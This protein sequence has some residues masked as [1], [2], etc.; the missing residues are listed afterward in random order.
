MWGGGRRR[1]P[2]AG[3]YSPE[4]VQRPT[5]ERLLSPQ[6]REKRCKNTST[7]KELALLLP[8]P[9]QTGSKK[10]TKKEI[11]Q[12]VL[13]YIK[14][15]QRSI[16]AAK[17]VLRFQHVDHEVRFL[18]FS[19]CYC[20]VPGSVET[21]QLTGL[22]TSNWKRGREQSP[23]CTPPHTKRPK[24]LGTCK[25]PRKSR[26]P[27][28]TERKGAPKKSSRSLLLEKA[29]QSEKQI[30]EDLHAEDSRGEG[31]MPVDPSPKNEPVPAN[32]ADS[33]LEMQRPLGSV[34][35]DSM[36]DFHQSSG[37]TLLEMAEPSVAFY[38]TECC[39]GSEQEE[40]QDDDVCSTC[41]AHIMCEEACQHDVALQKQGPYREDAQ[42]LVNYRSS[43]E[44]EPDSSP[45]LTAQSPV[46]SSHRQPL[47]WSPDAQSW[48]GAS[49]S[50]KDL[51]L[52]PSL[53]T[54][55]GRLLLGQVLQEGPEDLS[56][57]LFED[58]CL[59]PQ[60]AC[61]TLSKSL[62]GNLQAKALLERVWRRWFLYPYMV[63]LCQNQRVLE[64]DKRGDWENAWKRGVDS[65]SKSTTEPFQPFSGSRSLDYRCF[66]SILGNTFGKSVFLSVQ[67]DSDQMVPN[68]PRASLNL[69]QS[70]FSLDHCYLSVS[71]TSRTDS[72]PSSGVSELV[73]AWNRQL[74]QEDSCPGL[75][76]TASSSEENDD[77]TWTPYQRSRCS[78]HGNRKRKRGHGFRQLKTL[79]KLHYP[80][81]LKKK[82]VN[83]FIMFCRLN[84]KQYIR[85]RPGTASTTAT[86]ELAYLWRVMSKQER[87]PYCIK[88]R[89]F[90]RLHNRVMRQDHV[91]SEEEEEVTPKPLHLLLAEKTLYSVDF[92]RF[93]PSPL[94]H[95]YCTSL[96]P[97]PYTV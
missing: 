95:Q 87:R 80:F 32:T 83:G 55:P 71:E 11:L 81:P 39:K 51:G 61:S 44:E 94:Y 24:L 70:A 29:P 35:P 65:T 66:Q 8:I 16:D 47:R 43:S 79:K 26:C 85:A 3:L 91:S 58:V 63:D 27:K 60:F 68:T 2:G 30:E 36:Q 74:L 40:S 48:C 92:H 64:R 9:L 54:S 90:S 1:G 20:A 4:A 67:Q 15:L 22:E 49:W 17:S 59:S 38:T 21:D 7:L 42:E 53:F 72:S 5:A 88:A 31:R 82:C 6:G 14:H 62:P 37:I 23:P 84:R 12:R 33:V 46:F 78:H 19:L 89:K 41:D 76:C 28:K 97:A 86:K 75:D 56:Q 96:H 13:L 34:L 25:K 10:L 45:W 50:S 57:V 73:S 69:F 93:V 18:D 77:Y 52:S